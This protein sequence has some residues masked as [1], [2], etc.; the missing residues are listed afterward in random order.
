[1]RT[2][3]LLPS[4]TAKK[5]YEKV[6][7]LPIYDYHCHLSPKEI[8]EDEPFDNIGQMWLGGDHYKWR[9]MRAAG[10]PEEKITGAADWHEKFLAYAEAVALAAGNPLYDWTHRELSQY[11]GISTPLGPATAEAIWQEANRVLAAEKLSPRKLIERSRVAFIA[12]TDDAAD[13]LAYHEKLKNDPTLQTRVTPSFRA[14][15]V[16]LLNRAGYAAYME[17]LSAVSGVAIADLTGLKAALCQ[18]LSHFEKAG[19]RFAD[20]G[21]PYF[22]DGAGEEAA[23]ER[24]FAA[25]LAGKEAAWED[26]SAF[27]WHMFLFLGK[28]C[29]KRGI[30]LQLH[31]AVARNVNT[32]LFLE[33]GAD[34]GG[35][36]I[37]DVIPGRKILDLLD[38]IHRDG[39]LPQT[40]LYTLN[41]AM[42][43]QLCS[44]AGSFPNVRVGAAWWF[45]DHK[46]GIRDEIQTIAEIHH[47]GSFLGMLTDSRS[48]LSYARHDYFRRIL[49]GI[50]ADW[51]DSGE[52]SGDTEALARAICF[53]NI[54][55]LIEG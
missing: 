43:A 50:L 51:E 28:E 4:E 29:K 49:C 10:I 25:A 19:C 14:D 26:D 37:G 39:G 35:D 36:C 20:I 17:K 7:D 6:K 55:K 5:L 31:L 30:A 18:R 13:D 45:N 46:R 32:P 1:M 33:K 11:F 38:A 23:A 52:F 24:A 44:I 41:P 16:W 2:E 9:L 21:I 27:L 47:I 40:I 8:W 12:T 42:T 34:C 22:P 54:K 48:F 53:E 3:S 15:N